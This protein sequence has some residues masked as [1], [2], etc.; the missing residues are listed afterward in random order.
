MKCA[1]HND[2]IKS[3]LIFWED[4]CK[5]YLC[6]LLR[7]KTKNETTKTTKDKKTTQTLAHSLGK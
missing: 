2:Q 4:Q 3:D 5:S 6:S 1:G 7:N